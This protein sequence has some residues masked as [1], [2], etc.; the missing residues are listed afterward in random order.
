MLA[1]LGKEDE[2]ILNRDFSQSEK[3]N[4]S[5]LNLILSFPR[6]RKSGLG[7]QLISTK[8]WK[9][10]SLKIVPLPNGYKI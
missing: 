2:I 4:G 3:F 8:K 1:L 5:M 6:M 9:Y 7:A 10:G